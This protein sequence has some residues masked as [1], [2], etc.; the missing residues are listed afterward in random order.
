MYVSE[1][2][3]EGILENDFGSTAL[4]GNMRRLVRIWWN[5]IG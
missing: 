5:S 2:E 3:S 1:R 4:I